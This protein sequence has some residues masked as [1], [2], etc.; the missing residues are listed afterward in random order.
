[1]ANHGYEKKRQMVQV[2]KIITQNDQEQLNIA[3]K[4]TA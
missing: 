1:M 2:S 4:T 3:G